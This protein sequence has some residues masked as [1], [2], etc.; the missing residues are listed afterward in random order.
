VLTALSR[1]FIS[2]PYASR[3]LYVGGLVVV[4]LGVEAARDV[5]LSPAAWAV[6][7]AVLVVVALSNVGA[8]RD[9]GRYLRGQ[10]ERT[11][12]DLAALDIGRDHLAPGFRSALVAGLTAG[13]YFA[14]ERALGTPA[15]SQASLAAAPEDARF[16]ADLE[17][18]RIHD[19]H[20]VAPPSGLPAAARPTIDR[21]TAGTAA[22]RGPC[23]IFTV[24]A[25]VPGTGAASVQ[26]IARSPAVE[27]A[28]G[29]GATTVG[30]RR[31]ADEF[32]TVATVATHRHPGLLHLGAD[33]ASQ[34]WR[35]LVS[36]ARRA[37]VCGR[38]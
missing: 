17:L 3:Y 35:L 13:E 24:A 8:L 23:V 15:D 1:A 18:I 2:A 11:R 16:I 20:P 31:F 12:A 38:R 32:R 5:R 7:G 6:V 26:L 10:A 4:L 19:V 29:Q 30:V 9:G 27:V 37:T 34:P 33:R 14:A 36:P 28:T 21:M 22:F 25:Y